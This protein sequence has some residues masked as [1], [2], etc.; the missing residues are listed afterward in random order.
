MGCRVKHLPLLGIPDYLG[1]TGGT[2]RAA[3]PA[4]LSHLPRGG[5]EWCLLPC[6][7][8]LFLS[9]SRLQ[10]GQGSTAR[11]PVGHSRERASAESHG[12]KPRKHLATSTGAKYHSPSY[13]SHLAQASHGCVP[14]TPE[15]LHTSTTPGMTLSRATPQGARSHAQH[16]QSSTKTQ[17]KR[18]E[19]WAEK[20]QNPGT[21]TQ[22]A[23]EGAPS[24]HR[25]M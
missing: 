12:H 3:P 8:W 5:G 6:S 16:K 21:D 11:H 19:N 23:R 25:M 13:S 22:L 4:L 7:L 17:E 14:L 10:C 1:S 18:G 9:P 20:P 15:G 2:H 24:W